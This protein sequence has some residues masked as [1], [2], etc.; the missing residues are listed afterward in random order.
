MLSRILYVKCQ[1]RAGSRKAAS[2][3]LEKRVEEN[4]RTLCRYMLFAKSEGALE[5]DESGFEEYVAFF[6]EIEP[7]LEPNEGE[8][9]YMG[10]WA[11]KLPGNMTRLA[12]LLHCIRAFEKGRNPLDTPINAKEAMEAAALA[13]FFLAHAK[14]VYSEQ[15]EPES[16]KHA[17][18]LWGKIKAID[19]PSFHKIVLTRKINGKRNFDYAGTLQE[20]IDR[21]YIRLENITNG[22]GRPT[23]MIH[24]NPKI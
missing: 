3:P 2:K 10:D 17:R 15:S 1:S 23:E 16:V 9:A 8:L 24:V 7:Q 21:G 18:Y 12:G 11:G 22:R 20:L 19:A 6:N 14:A 4:Y 13:R 5:Y